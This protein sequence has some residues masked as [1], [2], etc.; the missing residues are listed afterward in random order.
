MVF[1]EGFAVSKRV[2]MDFKESW[3]VVDSRQPFQ[4]C[5]S[6]KIMI[7]GKKGKVTVLLQFNIVFIYKITSV[8]VHA[9]SLKEKK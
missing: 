2:V 1:S 8:G 5:W 7:S 4:H 3:I 6:L 9:F